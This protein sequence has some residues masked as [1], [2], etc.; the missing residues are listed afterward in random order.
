MKPIA[1]ILALLFLSGGAIY[2]SQASQNIPGTAAKPASYF[3]TGK[4]YDKDM[5]GYLFMARTYDPEISRWTSVDPTGFPDGANNQLYAPTATSQL[6]DDGLH[7]WKLKMTTT[8][9]RESTD[10]GQ[11]YGWNDS[12]DIGYW[13]PSPLDAF[14]NVDVSI[15]PH[16]L[17]S[18]ATMSGMAEASYDGTTVDISQ[19]YTVSIDPT[20]G[21]ITI[22]GSGTDSK[23]SSVSVSEAG[24]ITGNGTQSVSFTYSVAG[25]L[26]ATGINN[27]GVTIVGSGGS[28][29]WSTAGGHVTGSEPVITFVAE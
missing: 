27:I 25:L 26:S 11:D 4:P 5:G 12:V 18:S 16:T 2:T 7:V 19:S 23:G 6:D 24:V 13:D 1:A 20:T 22:S 21:N 28:I 3:Y 14:G 10:T 9:N 15:A 8:G 17:A 29:G